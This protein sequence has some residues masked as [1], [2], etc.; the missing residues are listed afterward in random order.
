MNNAIFIVIG[1]FVNF[2]F[3]V[4]SQQVK[5]VDVEQEF[6]FYDCMLN[7]GL[8]LD[9]ACKK[10]GTIDMQTV[11]FTDCK[12]GCRNDTEKGFINIT[13][14]IPDNTPCGFFGETCQNGTCVGVCDLPAPTGCKSRLTT[15]HSS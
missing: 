7:L 13:F 4:V 14:N 10:F 3:Y 5:W 12:M 2:L 15:E 1:N 6:G 11:N 8:Q 9:E